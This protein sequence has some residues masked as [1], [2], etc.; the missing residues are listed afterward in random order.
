V[1]VSGEK[2]LAG[3]VLVVDDDDG[4]RKILAKW[5]GAFG[6][7]A[8]MVADAESAL[9]VLEAT[10]I[11]GPL[12]D[13]KMPGRDGVWLVDQMRQ[14]HPRVAIIIATGLLELDPS[15]TWA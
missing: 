11:D 6:H 1:T 9:K 7:T 4:V 13:M 2:E 8:E 15:V 10:R 5:V 12:C 3:A 14:H